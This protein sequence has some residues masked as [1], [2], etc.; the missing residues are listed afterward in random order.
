MGKTAA[1]V[2]REIEE[3]RRIVE[4]KVL[5]LEER[6]RSDAGDAR[7][8]L[9]DQVGSRLQLDRLAE[10]RPLT[11]LAGAFSIGVLLGMFGDDAARG[12][13]RAGRTA[14][15]ATG[16]AG[17]LSVDLMGLVSGALGGS[18]Q[19]ELREFLRQALGDGDEHRNG[20]KSANGEE[21]LQYPGYRAP[22]QRDW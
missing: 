14:G 17:G 4:R 7:T 15:R 21:A 18:V 2:Q 3:H 11:T 6:L 1:E 19:H 13:A 20:A 8:A 10:E 5:D 16:S 12:A 9:S 22:A